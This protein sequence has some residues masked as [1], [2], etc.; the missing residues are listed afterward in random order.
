MSDLLILFSKEFLAGNE[1]FIEDKRF[2]PYRL[3]KETGFF[4]Y[5]IKVK[6]WSL[7]QH[8]LLSCCPPFC[9]HR[10][11]LLKTP[12]FFRSSEGRSLESTPVPDSRTLTVIGFDGLPSLLA[13]RIPQEKTTYKILF[14]CLGLATV[15]WLWQRV[16]QP[17]TKL[18]GKHIFMYTSKHNF[19]FPYTL[20][21]LIK[22]YNYYMIWEQAHS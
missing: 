22:I 19:I 9:C 11:S 1:S 21:Y 20:F 3:E 15:I 6:N 8:P 10:K 12:I 16:A 14:C 4:F 7:R 13:L 5:L 17:A 2:H 18:P